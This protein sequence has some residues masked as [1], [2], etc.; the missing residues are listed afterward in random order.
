[1]SVPNLR[2]PEFNDEWE[3]EKL[4]NISLIIT[5]GTTPSSL[6]YK[7]IHKG[8]NFI[9]TEN[10]A[11]NGIINIEDTPKISKECNERLSRS[12]LKEHDILFSIAGTLGRTTIIKK[13]FLPANTNQA[14]AIVRLKEKSDFK[15]VNYLLNLDKVKRYI[16]ISVTVGAQP[17][18]SLQQVSNIKISIPSSKE[19][20]KIT[21]FLSK[22]D[23]KIEKL[24]K[25]EKLWQTYKNGMMQQLFSQKLRFKDEDGKDYPDW[26]EK[27]LGDI[28]SERNEKGY[29]NFQLLSVTIN[30]GVIKRDEIT[31]KDNSSED[32]S[33]YKRVLPNDIPYNSMRMWQGASGVS[34]YMGIVSPA[35]TVLNPNEGIFSEFFG[36]YF[37]SH[38]ALYQFRKYSQGL[39]S[40]TWNLKYPLL[41]EIKMQ[42]P[43]LSEQRRIASFLSSIDLKIESINKELEINKEFKKGL[44]QQMFPIDKKSGEIKTKDLSKLDKQTEQTAL[45]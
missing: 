4:G 44:L 32:K 13:E 43:T 41:S 9:K 12:K 40:D 21:S 15:F 5:K 39:T 33:N 6:G 26:E 14:L 2:F 36:Y 10:I 18:L 38:E 31:G 24:E 30:K 3:H 27:K 37:K 23:K 22:V 1:M 25:K 11:E 8:V 16:D 42:V 20:Q 7:F 45:L 34:H 28:F 35:Y 29:S 19:Q 17:N